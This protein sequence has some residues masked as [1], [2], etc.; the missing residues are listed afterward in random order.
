VRRRRGDGLGRPHV[1]FAHCSK[2]PF[3]DFATVSGNVARSVAVNFF[4]VGVAAVEV[5]N[6]LPIRVADHVAAPHLVGALSRQCVGQRHQEL[7]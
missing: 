2:R 4:A 7:C 3:T 5:G 6:R 1:A